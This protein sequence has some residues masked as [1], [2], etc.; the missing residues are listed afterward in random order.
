MLASS[1]YAFDFEEVYLF[2]E[3]CHQ[4]LFKFT[5]LSQVESSVLQRVS[6]KIVILE[7]RVYITSRSDGAY[8]VK[9]LNKTFITIRVYKR[10]S[11]Y[12]PLNSSGRCSQIGGAGGGG[13][14]KATNMLQ[15]FWDSALALEPAEDES[16]T[17]R[18]VNAY[19]LP[20]FCQNWLYVGGQCF[21]SDCYGHI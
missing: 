13:Q 4:L 20:C 18:Y 6:G 2:K 17:R 12:W 11:L 10:S 1:W 16:D 5:L 9:C 14:D 21:K 8:V 3:P 19:W 7:S 15:K